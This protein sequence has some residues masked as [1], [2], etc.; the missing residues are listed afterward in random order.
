M[1]DDHILYKVLEKSKRI[2]IEKP[3]DIS[4]QIDADGKLRDDISLK[5]AMILMI[6][7]IED[8]DKFI[9]NYFYKKHCMLNK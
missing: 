6:C 9:H 7:I 5:N 3:D 1:V 2:G 4:I 8:S